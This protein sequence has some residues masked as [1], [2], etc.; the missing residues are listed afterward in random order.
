MSYSSLGNGYKNPVGNLTAGGS[1]YLG[2]FGSNKYVSGTKDFLQSNTLVAKVVFLI[3]VVIAFIYILRFGAGLIAWWY[4]PSP[5][6]YLVKGIKDAKKYVVI[7]QDP[8]DK[9]SIT[10][11][12]S[13]NQRDGLEFTYSVWIFIDDLTYTQALGT[14]GHIFHKG[15]AKFSSKTPGIAA[16]NNGPGLYL[17]KDKNSI[18][19]KMNTFPCAPG[20][21]NSSCLGGNVMQEDITVNDIPLNKWINIITRLDGMKMDV[22]VN[23]TIAVRHKFKNVPKQNYG[24]VF[25]NMNRGYSGLLSSL[26]YFNRAISSTEILDIVAAGPNMEADDSLSV[27]P[28]YFSLNWYFQNARDTQ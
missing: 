16:P 6:P 8:K 14:P 17:D 25:V 11:L 18:I 1:Q 23:G 4:S 3:L 13:N 9:K 2:Q 26:R 15:S 24:D 21:P 7:P 19:I 12:R 28:P 5:S 22:Y 20:T 10:L 27:F